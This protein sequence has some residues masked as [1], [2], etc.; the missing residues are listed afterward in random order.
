[1][2]LW[3]KRFFLKSGQTKLAGIR[4]GTNACQTMEKKRD[5]G[6][7]LSCFGSGTTR[8][9]FASYVHATLTASMILT[10]RSASWSGL[11]LLGKRQQFW[12]G[13]CCCHVPSRRA[14]ILNEC[15]RCLQQFGAPDVIVNSQF[16][17]LEFMS[18]P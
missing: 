3:S 6:A 17:V 14:A 5:A 2:G 10:A 4:I 11:R 16:R 8:S 18:I 12:S 13:A 7:V 9:T 15:S 1:M